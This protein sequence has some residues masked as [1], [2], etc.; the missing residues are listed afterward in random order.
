MFL[1]LLHVGRVEKQLPG[2]C[3]FGGAKLFR[4]R[5]VLL[6]RHIRHDQWQDSLVF[7]DANLG[8]ER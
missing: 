3:F 4:C 6:N 8:E 7:S 5:R 2:L 1:D